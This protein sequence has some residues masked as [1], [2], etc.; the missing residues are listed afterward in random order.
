MMLGKSPWKWLENLTDF[1]AMGPCSRT[2]CECHYQKVFFVEPLVR[3][4]FYHGNLESSG[5]DHA[6]ADITYLNFQ[7]GCLEREFVGHPICSHFV[8]FEWGKLKKLATILTFH[9]AI[10]LAS[11]LTFYRAIYLASILTF[12]R[13][14]YLAWNLTFYRAIY[15]ASILT[16][17]RAIYLA[18]RDRDIE[19]GSRRAQLGDEL[20]NP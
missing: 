17:Y 15:L 19:L 13:A 4:G 3:L 11:I 9:R 5:D 2:V 20:A 12:H 14:I 6:G 1:D 10:Y 7:R 18:S 16:F 8:H